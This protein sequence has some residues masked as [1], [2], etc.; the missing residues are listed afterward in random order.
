MRSRTCTVCA[1]SG[2]V[3]AAARTARLSNAGTTGSS[4]RASSA[5]A[6]AIV[7]AETTG[8]SRA[9]RGRLGDAVDEVVEEGGAASGASWTPGGLRN[10]AA[11]RAAGVCTW[12]C[13][14]VGTVAVAGE[15]GGDGAMSLGAGADAGVGVG[16]GVG[17]DADEGAGVDADADAEAGVDAGVEVGL[18]GDAGSMGVAAGAETGLD[19]ELEFVAPSV[20]APGVVAAKAARRRCG[21]RGAPT[22]SKAARTKAACGVAGRPRA[23]RRCAGALIRAVT[24][25]SRRRR[26]PCGPDSVICSRTVLPGTSSASLSATSLRPLSRAMRK[27]PA[28]RACSTR[29]SMLWPACREGEAGAAETPSVGTGGPGC[30]GGG[31]PIAVT[32]TAPDWSRS[33]PSA[34]SSRGRG[35]GRP[36]SR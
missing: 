9:G 18:D 12:A 8:T 6:V 24:G 11:G 31:A 14:G 29:T 17:A 7:R 32:I 30:D 26:R 23:A 4:A 25:W 5:C 28:V 22:S 21:T 13:D 36:G 15:V 2:S 20:V 19:D 16:V 3:L 33:G 34:R 1:T 35:S 27:R 10:A